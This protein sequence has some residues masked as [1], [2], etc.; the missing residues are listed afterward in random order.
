MS[1][2]R[3]FFVKSTPWQPE[4]EREAWRDEAACLDY[5]PELWF[6]AGQ[7]GAW[8][9]QADEAKAICR[10]C[11]VRAQCLSWALATRQNHGIWG[12][13]DETER[14]SLRRHQRR[15]AAKETTA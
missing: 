14:K 4:L 10:D 8:S 15:Y 1:D 13:M 3:A 5:D 9:A 11:P 2:P 7:T 12:G 6:P